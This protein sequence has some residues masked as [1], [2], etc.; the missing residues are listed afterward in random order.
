MYADHFRLTQKDIFQGLWNRW[1]FSGSRV[2]QAGESSDWD[3]G[4]GAVADLVGMR[5]VW[6]AQIKLASA[7][8][9]FAEP[10]WGAAECLPDGPVG[11]PVTPFL[12]LAVETFSRAS[13]DN[14]PPPLTQTSLES[15]SIKNIRGSQE[16]YK[17]Q[18]RK[19]NL[20]LQSQI[21][22]IFI[23]VCLIICLSALRKKR[24]NK[25]QPEADKRV[26]LKHI[27]V[28]FP[29]V[30]FTLLVNLKEAAKLQEKCKKKKKKP[31]QHHINTS[32]TPAHA[33]VDVVLCNGN[34]LQATNTYAEDTGSGVVWAQLMRRLT[35]TLTY[36]FSSTCT[37]I[38]NTMH[39]PSRSEKG[40]QSWQ[41][42]PSS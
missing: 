23:L 21:L 42:E 18:H 16:A 29:V 28:D 33:D 5:T 2:S 34:K 8:S 31:N 17:I 13:L 9:G 26:T 20:H 37:H 3:G 39:L 15:K 6:R 41:P 11:E 14:L 30:S 1:W 36:H 35:H 19:K 4:G 12:L 32:T 25:A 27:F 7:R 40:E 10:L 22:F 38:H 24:K